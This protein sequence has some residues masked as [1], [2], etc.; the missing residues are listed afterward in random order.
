MMGKGPRPTP[1]P[2]APVVRTIWRMCPGQDPIR[3]TTVSK[4]NARE[5]DA[6]ARTHQGN[7][8][9]N[10]AHNRAYKCLGGGNCIAKTV[11]GSKAPPE[12]R[13]HM[14]LPQGNGYGLGST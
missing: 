10:C 4:P 5:A 12:S 7:C 3:Y 11:H 9:H 6:H 14:P 13:A 1:S 8:A 2:T